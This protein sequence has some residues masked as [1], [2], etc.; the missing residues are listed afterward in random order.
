[1]LPNNIPS[2]A[3]RRDELIDDVHSARTYLMRYIHLHELLKRGKMTNINPNDAARWQK[4][5]NVVAALR[6]AHNVPDDSPMYEIFVT[7]KSTNIVFA[8]YSPIQVVSKEELY[9]LVEGFLPDGFDFGNLMGSPGDGCGHS[10]IR[11]TTDL[12]HVYQFTC[13]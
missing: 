3:R 10:Y 4:Q 1:M 8:C 11:H 2:L 12:A 13:N 5:S 7:S 9:Q 6:V